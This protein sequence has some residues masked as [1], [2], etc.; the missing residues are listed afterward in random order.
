MERRLPRGERGFT[1][2]ELLI[3]ILLIGI[4]SAIAIPMFLGKRERADDADAKTNARNLVTKVDSCYVTYEDF[5]KC[6]TQ[7]DTDSNELSW[8]SN[9]GDVRVANTTK[10]SYD[11]VAVSKAATNGANHTYTIHRNIDA[12]TT[13]SCDP[14]DAGGCKAGAW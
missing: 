3:V 1:L 2:I 9:P 5:T 14:P 8:G 11:I 10:L 4:L 6:A 7:A 12:S 13:R